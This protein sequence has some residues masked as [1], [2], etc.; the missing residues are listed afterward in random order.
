MRRKMSKQYKTILIIS[1]IIAGLGALNW[2][3]SVYNFNFVTT[4]F[5]K[6]TQPIIYGFIGI[7]GILTLVGAIQW[8]NSRIIYD[9]ETGE[10]IQN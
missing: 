8:S 7:A 9:S 6:E 5:S 1:C 4:I 3:L 10:K 2:L